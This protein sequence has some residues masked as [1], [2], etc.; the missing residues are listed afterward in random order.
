M[1]KKFKTRLGILC[2]VLILMFSTMISANAVEADSDFTIEEGVLTKYNG[3]GG[4]VVIPNGVTSIDDRAFYSCDNLTSVTIPNGVT[5]IGWGA[6]Y[7]CINLKNVD[8]PDSVTS[9]GDSA[10]DDTP[11]LEDQCK[12]KEFV[13]VGNHILLE[14]AGSGEDVVIP[15]GV[16]NISYDAFYDSSL[17]SV[18]IPNSVTSIEDS[19][20]RDCSRL[21][22]ITIPNSVTSIEDSAFMDCSSLTSVTIHNNVTS[23]GRYAFYGCESL[24]NVDIPNSVTSI[25]EYAFDGC[26][27]L[28]NVNIPDSVTS[29]GS[30]SFDDTPWL[31][32]QCKDKEF[33]IVGN[34]ILLKYAGSGENAVIPD[35]VFNIG[36][37]AFA[38]CSSLTSVTIPNS[39]TN[40]EDSAFRD[41]SRLTSVTIPNSVTSIGMHAFEG[42]SRLTSVT[43]PNSVTSIGW[44][45][46]RDCSGLTSV[47][48]SN[49]VTSIGWDA[50]RDCSGL[51]SVTIPNSVTSIGDFTFSGCS[52]LTSV[53]IPNSVTSIGD[54]AFSDCSGLTSVTIP[55]SVTSIG[56]DA[57][58]GCSSLTSVTIPNSVTTIERNAFFGCSSLT[59]V[60]IPNSLIGIVRK[61]F[62]GTPWYEEQRKGKKFVIV[63][64]HILL[65][66]AGSDAKVE[67]PDGVTSIEEYAF[68]G[69]FNLTDVNIPNSVKSIGQGAFLDCL[70][71]S[72]VTIPASVTE[73]G[74]DAFSYLYDDN[75]QPEYFNLNVEIHGIAGS[76]AE[77][78]AKENDM[79]FVAHETL[80]PQPAGI[81][82]DAKTGEFNGHTY[83]VFDLSS[84]WKE[85][86]E[87]CESLGGHLATIT[88]KE[89]NDFIYQFMKQSGHSDAFFGFTD[90]AEEGT[91]QWV[92]GEPVAFTNWK[93]GEPNDDAGTEDYAMFYHNYADQW[94][95]WKFGEVTVFICEWDQLISKQTDNAT[96]GKTSFSDV[97]ENAWY[98]LA[99]TRSR[100]NGYITGYEDGTFKP[101]KTITRAESLAMISR[102]RKDDLPAEVV[103]TGFIDVPN[104]VW[105]AKYVSVRGNTLGKT[106]GNLF[107]PGQPCTREEFAVGLYY[108][109]GLEQQD[110][111]YTFPDMEKVDSD[112]SYRNAVSAMGANKIMVGDENG[113]FNPKKSITRAEA[114][115]IFYN[116][117]TVDIAGD[118]NR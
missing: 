93:Q 77:K 94:N 106:A 8:I 117:T 16:T 20:F 34:H 85:A 114:A 56:W 38:Y 54:S 45:A 60:T 104:N 49:S 41:C 112:K 19:A 47:T 96:Q 18:T 5:S 100:E 22:S 108:A 110:W 72:K 105:Y 44:D 74:D 13:I 43:I 79:K 46:F 32:D 103:D 40:I 76:Y 73:I 91:W 15:D 80:V 28:K 2:T 97:P 82:S 39:V 48:I 86:K 12:D 23:I 59:S 99:V 27:S 107:R 92:T 55:N 102:L 30:H 3:S 1:F 61:V 116:Y 95:D 29:I 17:T 42:C 83:C 89:E 37:D 7:G 65:E 21:T 98:Y 4:S 51:T 113:N 66:Y 35:S 50:F 101:Q 53:T 75:V 70:N 87:Y 64:N 26:I 6:F 109:L 81:P 118:G 33:V 62:D 84:G 58:S 11:W 68:D 57:F 52:G 78:W 67:I 31:E 14:Y 115:Q 88:T 24:K 69:C 111:T 10:F 90:E 9:I 36:Y 25:G 71:L 63:G